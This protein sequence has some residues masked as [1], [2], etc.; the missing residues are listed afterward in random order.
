LHK[1][2]QQPILYIS[3]QKEKFTIESVIWR[4]FKANWLELWAIANSR[5]KIRRTCGNMACLRPNHYSISSKKM[6]DEI[7]EALGKMTVSGDTTITELMDSMMLKIP[8]T[9]VQ[10]L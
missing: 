6:A 10:I 2:F 9:P 7:V 4:L 1:K 8:N 5:K 3:V